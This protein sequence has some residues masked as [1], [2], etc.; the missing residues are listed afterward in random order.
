[1]ASLVETTSSSKSHPVAALLAF[2]ALLVADVVL[3]LGGFPQLQRIVKRWPMS[4]KHVET[5]DAT[6]ACVCGTVDRATRLYVK[7][8]WCLQRA[9]VTTCLLRTKGVPAEMVIGCRKMPF[10][11]HAWVEVNG[12]VVNDNE[13]VHSFYSV[14]YR[15]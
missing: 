14:L 7:H 8:T 10:H 1:M 9:A 6:I 12:R 11:G 5:A 4:R 13:M 3:K 2:F 15:C